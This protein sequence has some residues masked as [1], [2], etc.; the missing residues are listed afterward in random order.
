MWLTGGTI[1]IYTQIGLIMLV[2]LAA[3][4]GV[5]IVE[6]VNQ[7]REQGVEFREAVV[8]ASAV[9][10]RP[11]LMTAVTTAA[12]AVPLIL[13]S[14]AGSETRAAIGVVVFS[15]V[16]AATVFTLYL[17]PTAYALLA[18]GT[19]P[20]GAVSRRLDRELAALEGPQPIGDLP[21]DR[22]AAE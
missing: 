9:R 20:R 16:V 18:R 4:N 6:F 2:G 11:I 7:L 13:S 14:G 19:R 10:L 15:G 8:E 3:K 5:L 21:K 1:N 12:G 17:I 22:Q